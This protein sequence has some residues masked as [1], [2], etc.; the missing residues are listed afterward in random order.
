MKTSHSLE[1]LPENAKDTTELPLPPPQDRP[2]E[3]WTER[4][5]KAQ[6]ARALGRSLRK[7]KRL[8]F[9]SRHHLAR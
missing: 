5:E 2:A 1:D 8:L 3:G 7:G 6:E 4:A 9:S